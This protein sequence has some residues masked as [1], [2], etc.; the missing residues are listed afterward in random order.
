MSDTKIR[1]GDKVILGC[2][3]HNGFFYPSNEEVEVLYDVAGH[4]PPWVGGG[5]NKIPVI[6]PESAV[7]FSGKHD[8]KII[9]WKVKVSE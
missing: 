6:L 9:V 7:I 1:K 8:K 4:S 5:L 3:G 2:L